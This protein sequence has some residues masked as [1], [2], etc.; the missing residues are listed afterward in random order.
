MEKRHDNFLRDEF[1]NCSIRGAFQRGRVYCPEADENAHYRFR[2]A[3]RD[4]LS[5]R[6]TS[7]TATLKED[8]HVKNIGALSDEMSAA[9]AAKLMGGR[10]RIG[11]AQ[12]VLNLYLKYLW[13]LGKIPTPPHC[14]FDAIIIDQ[15]PD[16]PH[17]PWTQ[18][19][20]IEKYLALVS[21]AKKLAGQKSL[22]DWELNVYESVYSA[23]AISAAH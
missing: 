17:D 23:K 5:H 9:H 22:A 1:F 4:W 18:L 14:P 8:E 20:S 16:G 7:Y 15:L 11:I 3:L 2:E 10:F 13:C 12:K 19:D 6:E 21:A